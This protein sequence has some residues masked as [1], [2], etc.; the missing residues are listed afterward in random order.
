[1]NVGGGLPGTGDRATQG[2]PA[3]IAY[4]VAENEAR[5][6]V[7]AAARRARLPGRHERGHRDRVRGAAQHPGPLQ[8]HRPRH[9]QGDRGR[10]GP[11]GQQQHP[12]R[13]PSPALAR[14]RARRH[15][16]ARRL[17]QAAGEGVPRRARALPARA[18][19]RRVPRAPDPARGQGRA[20]HHG[21][22]GALGRRRHRDRGRAARASTPAGSP[23]SAIRPG[24]P[25]GPSHGGTAP[26][27]RQ[28][29]S[30][31][32]AST[33]HTRSPRRR[34][35][36]ALTALSRGLLASRSSCWSWPGRLR[37]SPTRRATRPTWP[38]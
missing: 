37:P 11:G 26:R 1:M 22:R 3:K 20:R 32:A 5:E 12:G 10:D 13:R 28:S 25:V 31:P 16:R 33:R 7:G 9:P 24:R 18:P 8:L 2:T 6:S 34:L 14:A 29:R 23:P 36:H 30:W 21:A 19:G 4:C 27:S 35:T 17:H 38:S 15:H